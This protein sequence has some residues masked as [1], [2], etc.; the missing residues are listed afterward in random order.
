MWRTRFDQ[1]GVRLPPAAWQ[2]L[3]GGCW[4]GWCARVPVPTGHRH[5][6]QTCREPSAGQCSALWR[7][8]I[9]STIQFKSLKSQ[10]K[11]YLS[12]VALHWKTCFVSLM[13]VWDLCFPRFV[14]KVLVGNVLMNAQ[15]RHFFHAFISWQ[16]V[17]ISTRI[18]F[19]GHM[20]TICL[21]FSL[22]VHK[23]GNDRAV[24]APLQ[25]TDHVTTLTLT[26]WGHII[27]ATKYTANILS[28]PHPVH[29]WQTCLQNNLGAHLLFFFFSSRFTLESWLTLWKLLA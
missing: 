26:S 14:M 29:F 5:T 21:C 16:T 17:K 11:L 1:R 3:R 9:Y 8:T 13:A 2:L 28:A 25:K 24:Y 12:I 22:I 20:Y 7:G 6:S 27:Q 4:W 15:F 19:I 10:M 18:K 23:S